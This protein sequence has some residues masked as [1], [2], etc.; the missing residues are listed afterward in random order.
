MPEG[1]FNFVELNKTT[2]TTSS[3]IGITKETWV[4]TKLL[5]WKFLPQFNYHNSQKVS[6]A[7][8][9]CKV[10]DLLSEAPLTPRSS[11]SYK[12]LSQV[13]AEETAA[14]AH[15]RPALPGLHRGGKAPYF[16]A[17][18]RINR[19]QGSIN[20]LTCTRHLKTLW[21]FKGLPDPPF[22]S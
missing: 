9:S 3:L 15:V 12:D 4:Q 2:T 21:G 5:T 8:S 7:V 11:V 13:R 1:N 16:T 14:P 17:R 6:K 22:S 18:H 20:F 10:W 19:L